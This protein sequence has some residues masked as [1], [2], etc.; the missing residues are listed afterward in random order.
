MKKIIFSIALV[1]CASV[2]I[3]AQS[4]NKT[5]SLKQ[6]EVPVTVVNALQRDFA[7]ISNDLT[8]GSWS[9][10][11][12]QTDSKTVKPLFYIYKAKKGDN[13][14]EARYSPTGE[15]ESSKGAS[16]DGSSGSKE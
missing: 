12:Q 10:L 3:Y 5:M 7:S 16:K 9:V 1:M 2:A 6:E 4:I 11:T 13:K 8:K 14:F 15:L